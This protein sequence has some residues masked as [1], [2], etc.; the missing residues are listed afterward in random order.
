[1]V[2]QTCVAMNRLPFIMGNPAGRQ[3]R[4]SYTGSFGITSCPRAESITL[5]IDRLD[6][7]DHKAPAWQDDPEHL[8]P[9]GVL[10]IEKLTNSRAAM[11]FPP[12]FRN[13]SLL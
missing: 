12:A 4:V 7:P 6:A 9:R 5:S 10:M 13:P 8:N 3:Q 1:M 2:Q 11:L